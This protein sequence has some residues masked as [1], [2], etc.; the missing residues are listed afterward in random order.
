MKLARWVGV[1]YCTGIAN[2]LVKVGMVGK[3]N[4]AEVVIKF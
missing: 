2:R 3:G 1:M 4:M